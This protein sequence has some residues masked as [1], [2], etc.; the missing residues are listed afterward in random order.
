MYSPVPVVAEVVW[1]PTPAQSTEA[2][3]G[4]LAAAAARLQKPVN[5]TAMLFIQRAFRFWWWF[6]ILG[7]CL[8]GVRLDC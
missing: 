7:H 1:A 8:A 5:G 2:A 3:R 4:P 6:C